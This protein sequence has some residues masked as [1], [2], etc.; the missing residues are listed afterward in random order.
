MPIEAVDY[1]VEIINECLKTGTVPTKW[2]T[3]IIKM[4]PK[5]SDDKHN[6]DSYRPISVTPCAMRLFERVL[7]ERLKNHLKNN[8][9]LIKQQSGFREKRST[10]DNLFFLTQKSFESFNKNKSTVAIFFDI[11]AAFDKVWYNGLIH[12][13]FKIH[14]PQ[15]AHWGA[16][17]P[18]TVPRNSRVHKL[19]ENQNCNRRLRPLKLFI[20]I[21]R[22]SCPT[23][24]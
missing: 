19:S 8:N 9:I 6:I 4:I 15:A 5:K 12:K 18:W 7:L 2:K 3:S 14:D 13:L 20:L 21:S 11:A 22:I 10:R 24:I 17:K 23:I 16:K 1:L